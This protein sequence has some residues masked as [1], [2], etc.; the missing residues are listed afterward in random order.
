MSADFNQVGGISVSD[1]VLLANVIVEQV[2]ARV[3]T[4]HHGMEARRWLC[5]I[6]ED[7]N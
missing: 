5:Q 2:R 3:V 7:V 6:G 1:S 4:S